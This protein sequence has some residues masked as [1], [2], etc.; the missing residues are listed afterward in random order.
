MEKSFPGRGDSTIWSGEMKAGR[1]VRHA[2]QESMTLGPVNLRGEGSGELFKPES[3]T[4]GFAYYNHLLARFW[5]C[6][7]LDLHAYFLPIHLAL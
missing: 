3:N 6:Y 1:T 4:V 2:G 7:G 5:Q